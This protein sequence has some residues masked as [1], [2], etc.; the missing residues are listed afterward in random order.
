V[1]NGLR[2][3]VTGF[4]CEW[5]GRAAAADPWHTLTGWLTFAAAIGLL[6]STG[7]LIGGRTREPAAGLYA[8]PIQP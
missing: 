8:A 7:R 1:V 2:V 3:A 5:W 6:A 4:A